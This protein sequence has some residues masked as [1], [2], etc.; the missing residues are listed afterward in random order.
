MKFLWAFFALIIAV[1]AGSS[2]ESEDA[3]LCPSGYF[4]AGDDTPVDPAAK[5][6]YVEEGDRSPT[7]S[8]YKV[9]TEVGTTD[10]LSATHHC[11]DQD[12]ALV[13]FEDNQ[14]K[15]RL[16]D[17]VKDFMPQPT[18]E[19]DT[20][21]DLFTSGM[22]FSD[23][24]KWYW[25]ASNRTLSDDMTVDGDPEG[26]TGITGNHADS[27]CL[28]M[29]TPDVHREHNDGGNDD[30]FDNGEG[31][32]PMVLKATPCHKQLYFVCEARVQ[33]VTYYTWF[34]ANWVDLMLGFLITI[35]F[36]SL[37]VSLCAFSGSSSR[38][39]RR[40]TGQNNNQNRSWTTRRPRTNGEANANPVTLD[41]P[42]SYD[43][44]VVRREEK[45]AEAVRTITVNE[46]APTHAQPS[47]M[48]AYT[49]KGKELFAKVY[50][51]RDTPDKK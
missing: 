15:A 40:P 51:Y 27:F 49:Q 17:R 7:Y 4:Y 13:S 9:V 23:V 1:S 12:A 2:K 28:A 46:T 34:Y 47:R 25:F 20:T 31:V 11:M 42:P 14:E 10:W 30:G 41:L 21:T 35:L 50:Y 36:I 26:E 3:R 5:D 39:S 22:Y 37:L 29:E 24:K 38:T 19:K 32:V 6:Y 44:V 45:E 33:T 18:G 8:C 43:N 16:L 48:S